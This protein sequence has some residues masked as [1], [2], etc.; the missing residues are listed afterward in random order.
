MS[1]SM[2]EL[3]LNIRDIYTVMVQPIF[4]LL[5][6]RVFYI[7]KKD[8]F[9]IYAGILLIV[10]NILAAVGMEWTN[11]IRYLLSAI[12]VLC[13]SY[14]YYKECRKTVFILFLFYNLHALS[15]LIS[16]SIYLRLNDIL[17]KFYPIE[18]ADDIDRMYKNIVIGQSVF[19]L[20]YTV[21]FAVMV[22]LLKRIVKMSCDMKWAE[23]LFLSVLNV[24]GGML[25]VMLAKLMV[26]EIDSGVFLLYDEWKEMLWQIPLIAVLLYVGEISAIYI[27]QKYMESRRQ[28][29][30]YFME[31]QQVKAMKQSL[32]EAENFYGSICKVRH[33]MKNH[34]TNIKGLVE[35]GQY[36]EVEGYIRKL[37]G[38]IQEL[39]YRYA[40]GNAVTDVIINDK[41]RK[42]QKSGIRFEADFH[43]TGNIPVFDIG[44]VLN[45]LLDN[46]IEACEKTEESQRYTRLAL[47]KKRRFLFIE[48]E[49]SFNG[50]VHVNNNGTLETWKETELPDALMEHGVGLS[51]VKEIAER[52]FGDMDI[53]MKGNVFKV[54]V[55]LQQKE[56]TEN[57][58]Y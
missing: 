27:Y 21:I 12:I 32:E 33:E 51:N 9:S 39:E 16:N 28:R 25:T 24:V 41:W 31:E 8:R 26:V 2:Y 22:I 18:T 54:T 49:N 5:L 43:Y 19:Y 40:T 11:G 4:F 29:E 35:R 38:T 7:I 58:L 57:D 30:K 15:F 36:E 34:M 50:I 55:M 56:R 6:W 20:A 17:A 42:A 23:V 1:Q 47:S 48:V 45:N 14:I 53:K 10:V 13:C 3:L 37:D 52:Y 46:A 44:I